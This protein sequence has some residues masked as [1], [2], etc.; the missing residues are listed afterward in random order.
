MLGFASVGV[1][2]AVA[3]HVLGRGMLPDPLTLLVASAVAVGIGLGVDRRWSLT[4]L[5]LGLVAVQLVVHL[6]GEWSAVDP[7]LSAA[8]A[9]HG[10][11]AAAGHAA[12]AGSGAAMLAWHLLA[13]PLSALLL[14]AVDRST[15][16]LGRLAHRFVRSGVL[17][18][19]VL[20]RSPVPASGPVRT[21][22]RPH[23]TVV[24]SNAPPCAV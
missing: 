18:L 20:D 5:L 14:V 13:V 1:T 8:P 11:A 24:R 16:A 3:G 2:L 10:H 7:R 15:A 17:R 21:L 23:L 9:A 12:G 22:R 6:A 4:R 19:P